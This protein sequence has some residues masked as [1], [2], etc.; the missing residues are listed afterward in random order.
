MKKH[1]TTKLQ[2]IGRTYH[3]NLNGQNSIEKH[4]SHRNILNNFIKSS[5]QNDLLMSVFLC[6]S[7]PLIT[8]NQTPVHLCF[9]LYPIHL[10]LCS[11][12]SRIDT[13][14]THLSE[15]DFLL[16]MV[17]WIGY[18]QSGCDFTWKN[19]VAICLTWQQMLYKLTFV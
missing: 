5:L 9:V 11:D 2:N 7:V 3:T 1:A 14:F 8:R 17:G 18:I 10:T 16:H 15:F 13:V 19:C 4:S 6:C 12:I